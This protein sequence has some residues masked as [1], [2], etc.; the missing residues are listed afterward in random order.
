MACLAV[1]GSIAQRAGYGGHAWALIQYLL[2]FRSLGYEVVFIDFLSSSMATDERGVPSP[3]ARAR[4]IDWFTGEMRRAGL[5][6]SY[7]LLLGENGH[8]VGLSRA[9]V[10]ERVARSRFLLNVMG[11]IDDE[12][13]LEAAPRRVFL[14]IDP[15]FCQMWR[16]LGLADQFQGHDD[17][18][19]V[20]EN[21]GRSDCAIPT[22]GIPWTTTRPPVHLDS[23]RTVYGGEVITSVGSWRGPYAPVEY[24]GR[25]YGLRVHE[26]RKFTELPRLTQGPF[27]V[28]LDIDPA[29]SGDTERL[30]RGGWGLSNPALVAGSPDRY[31]RYLQGSKAEVAIAK[32]MYVDTRSGWFSD[33]SACYL[34][35]GKPVLAQDTGFT[36]NYPVGRG[37]VSFGDLDEAVAGAED[38]SADWDRHSRGARALAEEYFDARKVLGAMLDKLGVG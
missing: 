2:G 29:D 38:I 17:F 27:E 24:R 22:C 31:R 5:E 18:V 30:K 20:A 28:A 26:F 21:I 36:D 34:A 14:D 1:A 12:E 33:R 4:S 32:E 8:S 11:F 10:L 7:A 25:S 3:T 13:I 23:W 16:E 35:S 6:G 15:G 37:L 9:E 19:T